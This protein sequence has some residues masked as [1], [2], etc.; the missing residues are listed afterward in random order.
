[1]KNKIF[2]PQKTLFRRNNKKNI[3]TLCENFSIQKS[4]LP[5]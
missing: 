1:V 2:P 5:S 4:L 3:L